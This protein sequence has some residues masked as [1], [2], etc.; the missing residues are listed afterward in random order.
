[1]WADSLQLLE[2]Q[3]LSRLIA[4]GVASVLIGALLLLALHLRRIRAPLLSQFAIQCVLWGSAI[5]IW[6]AFNYDQ[7]PLRDYEGAASL[8]RLLWMAIGARGRRDPRRDHAGHRRLDLRASTRRRGRW[9][10]D[11]RAGIARC[12]FSISFSCA[13]SSSERAFR[14]PQPGVTLR[15]YGRLFRSDQP[16]L[17]V[18]GEAPRSAGAKGDALSLPDAPRRI[19]R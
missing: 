6:G 12:S 19:S 9:N 17:R 14:L 11:R 15:P 3:H 4:W 1:M 10:R 18:R 8:A 5:I 7:V 2:Q 13:P 16:R